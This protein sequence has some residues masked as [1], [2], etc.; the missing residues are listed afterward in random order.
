MCMLLQKMLGLKE[1]AYLIEGSFEGLEMNL[2][3]LDYLDRLNMLPE[4]PS[5]PRCL[6]PI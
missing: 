6:S 2:R 4:A 1:D 5:G 3:T